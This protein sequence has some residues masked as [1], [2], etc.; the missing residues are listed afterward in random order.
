[1]DDKTELARLKGFYDTGLLTPTVYDER[2]R[3]VLDGSS[4]RNQLSH[5]D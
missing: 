5:V 3:A 2:Q 1:M 4:S